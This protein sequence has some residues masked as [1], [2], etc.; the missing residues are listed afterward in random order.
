MNLR[1]TS[2]PGQTPS[3]Y[4]KTL[5]QRDTEV[6]LPSLVDSSPYF[7][8]SSILDPDDQAFPFTQGEISSIT[9]LQ[10]NFSQTQGEH[11]QNQ[12]K[13]VDFPQNQGKQLTNR[14]ITHLLFPPLSRL[15][16]LHT[17]YRQTDSIESSLRSF[18][19]QVSLPIRNHNINSYPFAPPCKYIETAL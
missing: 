14:D 7:D 10:Y 16:T 4:I 5:P 12:G 2:S 11:V 17:Y 18:S 15:Q 9:V 8:L 3:R 19:F 6:P 13:Q 1:S